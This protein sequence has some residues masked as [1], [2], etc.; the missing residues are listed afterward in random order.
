MPRGSRR[1][2]AF[3]RR[4]AQQLGAT[5]RTV[6]QAAPETLTVV[7]YR[8]QPAALTIARLAITAVFAYGVALALPGGTSRPVLAPLTALLVVQV[9]LYQ[10]LRSAVRRV[11]AVVTGV[12]VAIGL[13]DFVGFTWW[14]LGITIVA[15][16]VLGYLLHLGDTIL[17]VPISAMLILS[18]GGTQGEAASGRIVET[19]IGA[20]AGLLA[21]LV[22]AAPR[23]QPAHEAIT[24]LCRKMAGLLDRMAGGLCDGTATDSAGRWLDEA[25]SL[26]GEIRRVDDAVREAEESTKLNPLSLRLPA[27]RA[28]L[29]DGLQMLEHAAITIRGLARSMAD[30]AGLGE[31]HSSMREPEERDR[32][33][34]VLRQLAAAVKDYGRLVTHYDPIGRELAESDLREHLDAARDGQDRL[35]LVLAADPAERPVGWPLRGELVSHIDRLRHQLEPGSALQSRRDRIR[36]WRIPPLVSKLQQKLPTQ[37]RK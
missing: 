22:L 30:L 34:G 12:L 14:S 29:G 17:E 23:V 10:T 26:A 4:R 21:G 8:A 6:A 27:E 15:A 24:E 33:A 11:A 3:G 2:P 25:R 37:S 5:A 7:R 20:G 36:S 35:S 1:I 16:L 18:V 28:S 32:L 13:S 31:D 9:T 19:L